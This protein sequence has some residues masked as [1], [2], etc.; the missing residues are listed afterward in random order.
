MRKPFPELTDLSLK[1]YH[2]SPP[3]LP[4]SFLGGSAPHLQTLTLDH[5]PFLAL[6]NILLSTTELCGLELHKIPHSGYIPSQLTVDC[7][8]AMTRLDHLVLGFYSPRS[9]P[10]KASLPLLPPTRTVLPALTYVWFLGQCGY[11]EEWPDL[12]VRI[13]APLLSNL[14]VTF[15]D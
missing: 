8:S 7:L 2:A 10:G 11:L 3:V 15:F 4:D 14:S 5:V 1:A 9:F 6:P 12:V 13:D